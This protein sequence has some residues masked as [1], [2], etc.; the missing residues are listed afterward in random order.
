[1]AGA[2]VWRARRSL[3]CGARR[4]VVAGWEAVEVTQLRLAQTL[5]PAPSDLTSQ[6]EQRKE[7][8]EFGES[9]PKASADCEGR[10]FSLPATVANPRLV[11][12]QPRGSRF[13]PEGEKVT[14]RPQNI[15]QPQPSDIPGPGPDG[16]HMSAHRVQRAGNR[17]EQ[18]GPSSCT[19]SALHFSTA[20]HP[21]CFSHGHGNNI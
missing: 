18:T 16:R 15:S 6:Q 17:P 9:N 21:W 10:R 2:H 7:Q 11:G 4:Q 5:Q 1:M 12:N 19:L 3:G 20:T 8:R 14:C 13:P